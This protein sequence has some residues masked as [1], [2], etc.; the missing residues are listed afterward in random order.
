M[1]K[2]FWVTCHLQ[3]MM[4]QYLSEDTCP[5]YSFLY[6]PLLDGLKKVGG[7]KNVGD[8]RLI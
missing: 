6:W 4:L 2:G 3:S 5:H 7:E 1:E 8:V